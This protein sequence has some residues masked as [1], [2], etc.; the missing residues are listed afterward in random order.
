MSGIGLRCPEA[1]VMATVLTMVGVDTGHAGVLTVTGGSPDNFMVRSTA[2]FVDK[3]RAKKNETEIDNEPAMR[4]LEERIA[5]FRQPRS[6]ILESTNRAEHQ[7]VGGVER[8]H[9]SMQA[10]A[11]AL[12]TDIR[13]R[14]GEG[15]VPGHMQRGTQSMSASKQ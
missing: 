7:S 5:A 11:R 1:H 2:S 9:Q 15:V 13:A 3:L 8:A 6:T 12:R 14:T 4:Q 10:A